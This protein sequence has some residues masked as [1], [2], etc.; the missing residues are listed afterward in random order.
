MLQSGGLMPEVTVRE[1]VTLVTRLHPKPEPVETTLKR[2]GITQFADQR[3]D[4]LSGGQTQRVRFAL[5]ICGQSELIVLDERRLQRGQESRRGTPR[6]LRTRLALDHRMKCVT[7]SGYLRYPHIHGDLLVF[8]SEEDIWLA[9]AD[10]GRA[11]RLS[12]DH[13]QVS[14]PRFARDGSR[15]AWTSWR[16]GNPE[17]Y[18]ADA[19]GNDA[20]RLT[21]WSDPRTR[22]TGWT[23]AGEVLAVSATGQPETY[24]TWAYAVPLEGSPPRRLPFGP[25]VDL[26]LE[27]TGTALLTGRMNNELAYWKR[28][29]GRHP[30]QAVDRHR[31][32]PPLHP[33]ARRPRRPA[34]QPDADRRAVVLPVRSRGHRQH[35][36]LRAGRQRHPPAYRS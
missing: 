20:G 30:R 23:R 1:L 31:P 12:A 11:W 27:E 8:A 28:Y 33:G 17:V 14:Y 3:V 15:I 2:A 19:E 36:L 32:G 35:L 13:A 9:P 34:G 6:R 25:V 22:V 18:A 26:A 29:R 4:R 21:Y 16:D 10:G 24:L 5:A 7:S